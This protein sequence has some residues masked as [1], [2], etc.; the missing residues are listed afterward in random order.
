MLHAPLLAAAWLMRHG[1]QNPIAREGKTCCRMPATRRSVRDATNLLTATPDEAAIIIAA[2]LGS[3]A[4]LLHL[5]A[6]CRRF[7]LKCIAAP[8]PR[9]AGCS[10]STA[11]QELEMWSI[12]EE[13]ARRWI[14]DCIDQERG[15]V[16]RRGRESW[17]G[18]M[19][20]VEVL[21]RGAVFGRSHAAMTLS[22]G[23]ARA[24]THHGGDRFRPA[25]SKAMMR[26]GRHYA[27]FTVVRG[28]FM[29]FGVIRPGW[30]VEGGEDPS[31][32]CPE[33]DA[34]DGHCFYAVGSGSR[35]PA[36][37]DWEG[38]QYAR[39]GDRIGLL[40]D[41]DQGTMTVYKNDERL[42]VMATGLS[43]E[44]SWAVSMHLGLGDS[45]RIEA[46]AAPTCPSVDELAQ[47]GAYEKEH[48]FDDD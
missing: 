29:F 18:L 1:W 6:A 14:A 26:A 5:A 36:Q 43:G 31:R 40:L 32:D 10:S 48:A 33:A 17:L 24:T 16:P 27:Q 3:A 15:W 8:S 42:G 22:E 28:R 23:G 44:Y 7:A 47:E 19:W 13:A 4:D 30:D 25:A 12:A 39:E 9:G 46:A 41:L 2:A 38:R 34:V 11:A 21:R 45:M 20:E 35:Y 37:H